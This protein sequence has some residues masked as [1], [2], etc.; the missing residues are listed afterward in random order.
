[1]IR[2][3]RQLLLVGFVI[4]IA[5]NV[6]AKENW[7]KTLEKQLK[8][9]YTL[10]KVKSVY[11]NDIL[12]HDI[13]TP[14][15]SLVVQQAGFIGDIEMDLRCVRHN[16]VNGQITPIGQDKEYSRPLQIGE[17]LY[18]RDMDIHEKDIEFFL[19][20]ADQ[21]RPQI[22]YILF[23]KFEFP[24]GLATKTPE[25]I[26]Q[27]IGMSLAVESESKV[28]VV[29][30]TTSAVVQ[31]N[32]PSEE[33]SSNATGSSTQAETPV[34]PETPKEIAP[35]IKEKITAAQSAQ[36]L[37]IMGYKYEKTDPQIAVAV[38]QEIVDRFPDSELAIKVIDR[39]D[40][41]EKNQSV[42]ETSSPSVHVEKAKESIPNFDGGYVKV[43][44]GEYLEALSKPVY[45]NILGENH[46]VID[47]QGMVA[48][49]SNQF[50]GM[51]IKGRYKFEHFS[52]HYLLS[53][54]CNQ[55]NCYQPGARIDVRMKA[56]GDDAYYYE[57]KYK[58]ERGEYVGWIGDTFWLFS[59]DMKR[60]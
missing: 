15:M 28:A 48:V 38:Y 1:M 50:Q 31:A 53:N 44:S 33:E 29:M 32:E 7:K 9:T 55:D 19:I 43:N 58:L 23:A 39:L 27:N 5:S 35:E 42:A 47:K 49:A 41:L 54:K 46:S 13:V 10:T 40:L 18:I 22:R 60:K 3:A 12:Y 8:E 17:R 30:P 14:G 56:I 45:K 52:L 37:Y 2:I 34:E 57:P 4:V 26:K 20:T 36:E 24:D 16:I 21:Q 59:I 11:E 51:L 6:S 25:Q